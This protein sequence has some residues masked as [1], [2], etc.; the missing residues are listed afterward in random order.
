MDLLVN[1]EF[2][3]FDETEG[4][5]REKSQMQ[6]LESKPSS[7]SSRFGHYIEE[8]YAAETKVKQVLV[9][10]LLAKINSKEDL[11]TFRA[12][13]QSKREAAIAAYTARRLQT[14]RE[15]LLQAETKL[16]ENGIVFDVADSGEVRINQ[17]KRLD[18]QRA[19]RFDRDHGT[20]NKLSDSDRKRIAEYY[21]QG[22]TLIDTLKEVIPDEEA[23]KAETKLIKAK[24]NVLEALENSLSEE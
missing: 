3:D 18:Y 22:N 5:F 12:E 17:E 13:A 6:L 23:V 15:L 11:E 10:D 14:D 7:F 24:L 20:S 19:H 1:K 9:A 16:N 21:L 2:P 8:S 4:L